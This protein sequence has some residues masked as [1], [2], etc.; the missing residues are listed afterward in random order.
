MHIQTVTGY[1]FNIRLL[2]ESERLLLE[3]KIKSIA[4]KIN[5]EPDN[6]VYWLEHSLL[7]KEL[8]LA[9][10][11]ILSFRR[12]FITKN[13]THKDYFYGKN[14][15]KKEKAYNQIT[16]NVDL[17]NVDMGILAPEYVSKFFSSKNKQILS[18]EEL[19]LNLL[20]LENSSEGKLDF[21]NYFNILIKIYTRNREDD[22]SLEV[23]KFVL[24]RTDWLI[25]TQQLKQAK[26]FYLKGQ[27]SQAINY[28]KSDFI[29]TEE[30]IEIYQT[31][32]YATNFS[33]P[34][35]GKESI[36]E[37]IKLVKE[38]LNINSNKKYLLEIAIQSL[39]SLKSYF[40][41][42]RDFLRSKELIELTYSGAGDICTEQKRH[43]RAINYYLEAAA[44]Q[45]A[46][47]HHNSNYIDQKYTEKIS[48]LVQKIG[49]EKSISIFKEYSKTVVGKE[50]KDD[51]Y[52]YIWMRIG[53]S[54][55]HLGQS[56]NHHGKRKEGSNSLKQAIE[57]YDEAY[58]NCK[59]DRDSI[60]RY[61]A[62]ILFEKSKVYNTRL[63][64][65][66]SKSIELLEQALSIDSREFNQNSL[67]RLLLKDYTHT[68]AN[69]ARTYFDRDREKIKFDNFIKIGNKIT[70]YLNLLNPN[71][72]KHTQ[73]RWRLAH[74]EEHKM[75]IARVYYVKGNFY[76]RYKDTKFG[77]LDTEYTRKQCLEKSLYLF[78]DSFAQIEIN[79]NVFNLK[80]YDDR[81]FVLEI[82]EKIIMICHEL[83]DYMVIKKY[84]E[85]GSRI[86]NNLLHFKSANPQKKLDREKLLDS[87]KLID[88]YR[89]GAIEKPAEALEAA[90][91]RKNLCLA[92]LFE[93]KKTK[94]ESEE[95]LYYFNQIGKI[96]DDLTA[97]VYWHQGISEI[98]TFV[99]V[100]TK[101]GLKAVKSQ[102]VRDK[103]F[104]KIKSYVADWN[105][106]VNSPCL[107][108][109]DRE[110]KVY[111]CLES[112]YYSLKIDSI[113]DILSNYNKIEKIILIPHRNL[114]RI[115]LHIFFIGLYKRKK[116]NHYHKKYK[117]YTSAYLPSIKIG[118]ESS[119]NKMP[120]SGMLLINPI[121]QEG[122]DLPHADMESSA[123]ALMSE[124][125]LSCDT[126]LLNTKLDTTC[127]EIIARL[128]NTNS[129]KFNYLHFSGH[130]FH[131]F[132]QP[133]QSRLELT[134]R[135]R[136][137]LEDIICEFDMSNFYLVSLSACET[138]ITS[139]ESLIEEYV[140]L[141][142][143]L[144]SHGVSYVLS[145]LWQ[146]D[147]LPASF[148]TMKFY[149][150]I[151]Y[152]KEHPVGALNKAQNWLRTSNV[153]QLA[154]WC[155]EQYEELIHKT[156]IL[157]LSGFTNSKIKTRSILGFLQTIAM[158]LR[159]SALD[160]VPYQNPYY[161][162]GF[163]ITGLM[164]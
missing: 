26:V 21:D 23:H 141:V 88:I 75:R 79:F 84:Q 58:K 45:S 4:A 119:K 73:E 24:G 87:F 7:L 68:L 72:K 125:A 142:S 53:Q 162:A 54:L 90:E 116:Y 31:G 17:N 103:E 153:E 62:K 12:A 157:S 164:Q 56:L 65:K 136:L 33:N 27:V 57:A 70:F 48:N 8:Y 2:V 121:Y 66:L 76:Y 128:K 52:S 134:N 3:E 85:I 50:L 152:R 129:I 81:Y 138:G 34:N 77:S 106:S 110:K 99:V 146:V 94:S 113:L 127:Q 37:Y 163:T 11:A 140:G 150:E 19:Y 64:R 18:I 59:V 42:S 161:W 67:G 82:I 78:K 96:L 63:R 123:L 158:N 22:N 86:L 154:Q 114:H 28:L 1:I 80:Q 156:D 151:F 101:N 115:P 93:S 71:E 135:E 74:I 39:L 16:A 61:R 139:P 104:E 102:V 55:Y 100:K 112:I 91:I 20:E 148:I 143:G 15:E 29:T 111:S 40:A 98:N 38:T 92:N 49:F 97:I 108:S 10:E 137:T 43:V 130:A 133:K 6:Y 126:K 159:E 5:S 105:T 35:I 30:I 25:N 160:D 60:G 41:S 107:Q 131:N 144:L 122:E 9:K 32:L 47:S 46:N 117:H 83:Q 13:P 69:L 109:S 124:E 149:N 155:D 89:I 120:S 36:E 95:S 14:F 147:D 51:Y 132:R 145:T 118:L 44:Y